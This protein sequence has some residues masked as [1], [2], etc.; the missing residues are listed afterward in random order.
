MKML[1]E[2]MLQTL[3]QQMFKNGIP[4]HRHKPGDVVSIR[5]LPHRQLFAVCHTR[6]HSN[7]AV[8]GLSKVS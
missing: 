2:D 3:L 5:Q 1:T 6:P 7:A 8:V 4:F